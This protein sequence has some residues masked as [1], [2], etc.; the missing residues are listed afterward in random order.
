MG[1][2]SPRFVV[3]E[4]ELNGLGYA[5]GASYNT[6]K[7]CLPGTRVEILAEIENWVRATDPN[8]PRV[9]WINGAA[10]TGKSAIAH[11]IALIFD[12]N[13][14]LGSFLCVDRTYLA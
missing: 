12:Q 2:L 4:L 1:F 6:S 7:Q 13:R 3:V 8:T 9:L 14:E 11:T 10:G 5:Y